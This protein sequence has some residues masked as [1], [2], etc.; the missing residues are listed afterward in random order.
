MH[1]T[2]VC[3]MPNKSSLSCSPCKYLA[4]AKCNLWLKKYA[5]V[6]QLHMAGATEDCNEKHLTPWSQACS[7]DGIS[8]T[9][10]SP[11]LDRELL[12]NNHLRVNGSK[13]E[14]TGFSYSIPRPTKELLKEVSGQEEDTTSG[15]ALT[16]SLLGGG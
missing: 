12:Y 10:L 1:V 5:F 13:I 15:G 7:R 2:L 6:L 3:T 16:S 9:P 8:N 14:Q 11:Y 4:A